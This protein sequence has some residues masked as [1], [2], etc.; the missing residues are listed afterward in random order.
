[1]AALEP[2]AFDIETS[3]LDTEAVITVAGFAH[4][5]RNT[6]LLNTGGRD[7]DAHRLGDALEACTTTRTDLTI[8][9]DEAA[10]L[11]EL[12]AFVDATLDGDTHY[13]TAYNGETWNGGFDLPFVRSACLRA[14]VA[15]PFDDLAYADTMQIVDRFATG[16]A[17]DLEG[18]YAALVGADTCD[19][20]EDS[21][22]AVQAYENDDWLPL[23]KHN[24]AD[25]ERTRELA[26][27]AGQFVPS[28]D[29]RM[30]N[31][32]PPG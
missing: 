10:L 9:D 6:L 8:V 3:G 20:F 30:K 4:E 27:L 2:V 21:A 23:L 11:G 18:V 16:E 24:L 17:S 28:S 13:L 12:T 19:P 14:D 22:A 1:M 7:A 15:W 31:L 5:L 26:V 32:G 25:I 29:F